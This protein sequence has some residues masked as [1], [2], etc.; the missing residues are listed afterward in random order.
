LPAIVSTTANI[1][2]LQT[3]DHCSPDCVSSSSM[4]SSATFKSLLLTSDD[5][6]RFCCC[7]TRVHS[8]SESTVD[9]V[10]G[11]GL[12]LCSMLLAVRSVLISD[13]TSVV[14]SPRATLLE[15]CASPAPC[16]AV[17][18]THVFWCC[19]LCCRKRTLSASV[20]REKGPIRSAVSYLVYQSPEIPLYTHQASRWSATNLVPSSNNGFCAT[21]PYVAN[22]DDDRLKG[23]FSS[24]TRSIIR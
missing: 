6:L 13:H 19:A 18:C 4:L 16:A 23:M 21:R 5:S 22:L 17:G 11:H 1:L 9:A 7:V 14:C 12:V 20:A 15:T 24:C 10:T 8:L 3:N 2:Y